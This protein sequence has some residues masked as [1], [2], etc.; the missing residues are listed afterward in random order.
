MIAAS[1]DYQA[2]E[3]LD[4]SYG[5]ESENEPDPGVGPQKDDVSAL[6]ITLYQILFLKLPF[7][8]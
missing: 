4:D 8:G 3:A 5:D 1:P 7:V 6:D 2:A